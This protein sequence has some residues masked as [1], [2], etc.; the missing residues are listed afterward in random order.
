MVMKHAMKTLNLTLFVFAV[1]G[2]GCAGSE[3]AEPPPQNFSVRDA[4]ARILLDGGILNPQVDQGLSGSDGLDV[5]VTSVGDGGMPSPQDM[6]IEQDAAP[7]SGDPACQTLAECLAGC[8]EPECSLACRMA[9]TDTA[10]QMYDAIFACAS[11]NEC[12]RPGGGYDQTCMNEHCAE[13]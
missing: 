2:F 1:T 12:N 8:S 5:G 11:T 6:A 9:A 3:E 4:S 13:E 7:P 10:T